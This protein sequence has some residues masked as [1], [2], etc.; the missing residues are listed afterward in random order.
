VRVAVVSSVF[1]R[2]DEPVFVE[3]T[4]ACEY[5]L[6]TDGDVLVPSG[7]SHRAVDPGQFAPRFAAKRAKCEPWKFTDADVFVWLDGSIEPRADLVESMLDCLMDQEIAFYP[8]PHRTSILSEARASL[9]LK[10]YAG[11][12]VIGQAQHYVSEG[13]PDD[14]GLWA[15]GLF[16]VRDTKRTRMFG[17]RWLEEIER[18]TLQD[19]I[20][21]PPVLRDVGLWP[22]PLHGSQLGNPLFKI[23]RHSDGS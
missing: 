21:L 20:S 14:W 6:I 9:P 12:D 18:W 23:R 7:W 17:R 15:A 11:Q 16:A 3:Q 19:Q 2:Y 22:A 10:K 1:G 13:H 8:H 5:V 4:V